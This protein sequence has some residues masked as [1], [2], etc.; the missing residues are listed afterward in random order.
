[1]DK[2]PP[3]VLSKIKEETKKALEDPAKLD[4]TLEATWKEVA[5]DA[6]VLP[7]E[8]TADLMKADA[9]LTGKPEPKKEFIDHAIEML[10]KQ[11]KNEIKKENFKKGAIERMKKLVEG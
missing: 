2:L 3:E 8:K 7:I 6:Q 11:G 10:K 1:M 4:Q 5:G 9:K